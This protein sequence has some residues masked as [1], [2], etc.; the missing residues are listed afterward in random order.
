MRPP[1]ERAREP[2]RQERERLSPSTLSL[3]RSLALEKEIGRAWS[4][5]RLRGIRPPTSRP[6]FPASEKIERRLL[7]R[8]HLRKAAGLIEAKMHARLTFFAER[9]SL[10]QSLFSICNGL[11]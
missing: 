10:F 5:L 2:E 9:P 3:A 6:Q 1:S 8:A 4:D 7:R 11:L